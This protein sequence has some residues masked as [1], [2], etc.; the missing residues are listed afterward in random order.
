MAYTDLARIYD[1]LM[2]DINYHQWV[3]YLIKHIE[4]NKASGKVL[5]D[6]GCGTG[7]IAI[8]LAL[9]GYQVVGMD[10][11]T[12]MLTQAE[13]K[14][15]EAGVDITFFQQ[16]IEELTLDFQVDVV[17]ATF[18]TLNYI[19]T[20][21]GLVSV[22]QRIHKALK[23]QGL[24]IFD[25]NTPYKFQEILGENTYTYNTDELV[26]IWENFYDAVSQVCQM[27][28]TFFALEPKSGRYLRFDETHLERAYEE[29]E[30]KKMLNSN[31]FDVLGIYGELAFSP[32]KENEERIFFVAKR[33][34]REA[35]K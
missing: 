14:A 25:L 19:T 6:L 9:R 16:D 11:S 34:A 24:L 18:D 33:I 20:R 5:L 22:F 26:Y 17:I 35:K 1:Q 7:S 23:D 29:Q 30:V 12:E 28:L 8:P 3:D 13:Q 10:I 2:L 4:N 15:R 32:P 31:G 21:E 27:D